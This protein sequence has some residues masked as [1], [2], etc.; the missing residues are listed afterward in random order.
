MKREEFSCLRAG[1]KIRGLI[2]RPDEV[3]HPAVII[4]HG[5]MANYRTTKKYGEAFAK[6]GYV[7][8]VYDFNGGGIGSH[9]SG[10]TTD[11]SVLTEKEDLKTVIKAVSELSYVNEN[12]ITLVGCSQGGFVSAMVAQ[13]LQER[14]KRLILFYP[15]LCIPDDARSGKMMFAKFDPKNVPEVFRCGPMKLGSQYVTSVL[16]MNVFD[17][18]CG[19]NGPV[20]IIHGSKDAVVRPEYSEK[21]YQGYLQTNGGIP[22]ADCQLVF[23]DGAN[24]GFTGFFSRL[25]D[26]YALFAIRKFLEGKSLLINVDVALTHNET[27]KLNGGGKC[28]RM[29]FTG[30][31]ES[32]YF[33]GEVIE[34][35][36]DEQIY[37]GRTPDTCRAKYTVHG[38]DYTGAECNVDIENVMPTGKKKNWFT[39]WVP[40]VH[41]DSA[42]LSF[43]NDLHCETYAEMRGKK[44]PFIHIWG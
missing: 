12:D 40:T 41:T 36:F 33:K 34:P 1:L 22:S 14:I 17:E 24:H 5:F 23:I 18:I 25:W 35:A 11:M 39:G 9:S 15:A 37:H 27:E 26:Q 8:V 28:V 20:L 16:G 21:A 19:Y 13:E 31:S 7:A 38:T 4:S 2:Y 6:M 32:G 43:I 30:H 29:H 44:G 10:K 42:V 3:K